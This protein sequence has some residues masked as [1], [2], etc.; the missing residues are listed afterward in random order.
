MNN[1]IKIKVP[2]NVSC[3]Q[4]NNTLY[5]QGPLG[6]NKIYVNSNLFFLFL[7]KKGTLFCSFATTKS[8]KSNIKLAG[9]L[10]KTISK[11]RTAL[12]GVVTGFVEEIKL[13]GVGYRFTSYKEK[14]L[15]L[16]IGFC[17]E[18]KKKIPTSVTLLLESPTKI[19]L[20]SY[21]FESLNQTVA[22]LKSLRK[23]D[24]YK[25]KGISLEKESISL[26]EFKKK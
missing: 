20:F 10:Q 1:L 5:I 17:N 9:E 23:I 25:G 11:L 13:V 14:K 3:Y 2:A 18:V 7:K 22:E 16:K 8:K 12:K 4:L 26:K 15:S 21:D 6:V 19:V 24:V